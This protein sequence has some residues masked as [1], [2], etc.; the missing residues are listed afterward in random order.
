M[1]ASFWNGKRAPGISDQIDSGRYTS[2]RDLI[3]QTIKQFSD[4]PAYT[5]LG[6]TISY[7]E[8]D[9]LSTQFAAYLQNHTDLQP[10]DRIAIQMPNLIQYPIVVYGAIKAGLI[11]VNTNPL[12]TAREMLHQFNDSGAK[13]LVCANIAGHLV[14]KVVLDTPVKHVVVTELGDMLPW[15]KRTLVNNV[16]KH[17][18]KMVPAYNLPNAVPFREAMQRGAVATYSEPPQRQADD[19]AVLQYTGGTTGV[20]KGAMLTEGNLLSNVLQVQAQ[21][22][23]IK[24]DGSSVT[25]PDG[26]V[27]IGPLPLYHIYAFNAHLFALFELGSHSILIANPRDLDTFIKTIRPWRFS[28]FIGINTLFAG[29]MNHPKFS[30]L[31]FSRLKTTISGGTALQVAVGERW[32]EQTGCNVSACYGLTEAS[33]GV[34][35]NPSGDGAQ[36]DTVGLPMPGTALKTIGDDGQETTFGQPGE[37]CIKGPQVMKGYWQR[38]DATAECIENGWLK[39]GD[40]ATIEEDGHVR[41]VDRLKDMVLVSGFNVYPNEIEDIVVKHQKVQNCAAIGV[42]DDNT[43]E[44]VKLFVIPSDNS[45]TEDEIKAYCREHLT[46]YKVPRKIVFREEL[47]MTP[48]GKVLRKELRAEEN[49][50][51]KIAEPA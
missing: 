30:S 22:S 32:A 41:I 25:D 27:V 6:L 43:G 1:E 40:V 24:S 20:A 42:P 47:P 11:I 44:A 7:R 31:D 13:A 15:L 19:I 23:E 49:S 34:T 50:K 48:V 21:R 16:I 26:D 33:P 17:V 2:L 38:P 29:L 10:G 8:I 35:A 5:S 39:T 14:E 18:K 28:M 4:R 3:N 9:E 36:L 37:L 51:K 12:Y 46:A 45:A